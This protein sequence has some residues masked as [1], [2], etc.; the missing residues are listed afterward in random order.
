MPELSAGLVGTLDLVVAEKNC[1]VRGDYHIFSTPEMVL[2]AELTAIQALKPYLKDG[3]SSVGTRVD[4]A[5]SAAT[6]LGQTV[7][8]KAV[9]KEVDRR[10]VLFEI[11]VRDEIDEVATGTHERF[12]V[13][14]DRFA[15]RLEAKAAALANPPQ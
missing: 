3:Q 14:L 1:T 2:L 10:R 6:L 5:H 12:I 4:I 8:S 7:T 15:A 9:V 13:D 11:E